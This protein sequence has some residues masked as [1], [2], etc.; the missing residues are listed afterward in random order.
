MFHIYYDGPVCF[1]SNFT[2]VEGDRILGSL[3]RFFFFFFFGVEIS[4]DNIGN[5]SWLPGG[6]HVISKRLSELAMTN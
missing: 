6:V 2:V 4:P 5:G 1:I 3:A